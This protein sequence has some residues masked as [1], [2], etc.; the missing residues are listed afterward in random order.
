MLK[1]SH[2]VH[3]P[4]CQVLPGSVCV[5]IRSKKPRAAGSHQ[6]RIDLER[7]WDD[8]IQQANGQQM[9]ETQDQFLARM[10]FGK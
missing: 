7:D 8:A 3:C 2:Q 4:K 6:V 9:N 1:A 10:I 5:G